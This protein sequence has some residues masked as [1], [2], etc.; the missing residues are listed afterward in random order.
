MLPSFPKIT[1]KL[2]NQTNIKIIFFLSTHGLH[3]LACYSTSH[4]SVDILCLF[5]LFYYLPVFHQV[6]TPF[7]INY[8]HNTRNKFSEIQT[9]SYFCIQNSYIIIRLKLFLKTAKVFV[10]LDLIEID[11]LISNQSFSNF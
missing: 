2:S 9:K 8:P 6:H 7:P 4:N 3:V 10:Y 1:H 5:N 11:L